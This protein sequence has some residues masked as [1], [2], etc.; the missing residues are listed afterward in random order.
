MNMKIVADSSSN[1][2]VLE[3]ADYHCVS[4]KIVNDQREYTD[5]QNLDV[6]AMVAELSAYQGKTSTSCPN[7]GDWLRAF[8]DSE[9]IFTVAITSQLSGSHNSACQAREVYLEQHPQRKVFCLDS[10]S[11]GPEM[12]LIIE[13]LRELIC[14]GLEFEEIV[15]AIREYNQ[16]TQLLFMLESVDNL[17]KNG[18]VS[19]LIAKAVGFLGIR[20]VAKASDEGTI[21]QLHKCRNERKGLQT[22]ISE[23]EAMGYSGGKVSIAHVCG[24]AL[25]RTVQELV[26][27]RWPGAQVSVSPC[28][29]LC[30]FYAERGGVLVGFET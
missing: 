1:L 7:V 24:E 5:D 12:V 13:K 26:R 6:A 30:S 2:F 20:I 22:L 28:G 19:P 11:T 4:L 21:Q 29:G 15:A 18:R 9:A 8:G 14:A 17:A 10:R 16:R 27:Q 25:G 23:M 3:G